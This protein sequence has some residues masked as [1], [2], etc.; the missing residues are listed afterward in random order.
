LRDRSQIHSRV[1][2]LKPLKLQEIYAALVAQVLILTVPILDFR[3]EEFNP[4]SKIG[5]A[6]GVVT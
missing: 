6:I 1:L 5:S 2:E 4:K 3:L